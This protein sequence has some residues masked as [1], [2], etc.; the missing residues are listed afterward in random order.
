M[1]V[2]KDTPTIA[3]IVA[4]LERGSRRE[5]RKFLRCYSSG[6][7]WQLVRRTALAVARTT[8]ITR[9]TTYDAEEVPL[10]GGADLLAVSDHG[11]LT[12]Q[13]GC[14][15]TPRAG[16]KLARIDSTGNLVRSR[17]PD[18]LGRF[19][20]IKVYPLD[21]L[22][23]QLSTWAVEHSRGRPRDATARTAYLKLEKA[24][25]G[26]GANR[27]LAMIVATPTRA[28]ALAKRGRDV[29]KFGILGHKLD[30]DQRSAGMARIAGRD[31]G[32]DAVAAVKAKIEVELSL[33][34]H[35]DEGETP[36]LITPAPD[37]APALEPDP[38]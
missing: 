28:K 8:S 26:Q 1:Y 34:D 11:R 32:R 31:A 16:K 10:G 25:C 19:P 37:P 6:P 22:L 36:P 24:M 13:A 17:T 3:T 9:V 4:I 30:R 20:L 23:E 35:D 21:R 12:S 33:L 2:W 18:R 7:V 14:G 5:V 29:E 15:I 27:L 38:T